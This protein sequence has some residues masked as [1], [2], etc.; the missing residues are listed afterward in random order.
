MK[1]IAIPSFPID[2]SIGKLLLLFY[3]LLW[4]ERYGRYL[5]IHWWNWCWWCV[6]VILLLIIGVDTVLLK[7][8]EWPCWPGDI[9]VGL[10]PMVLKWHY[11]TD[12]WLCD[13]VLIWPIEV[14][15]K[16]V[17]SKPVLKKW[18]PSGRNIERKLLSL[19][20]NYGI[21]MS[22]FLCDVKYYW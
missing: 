18:R 7:R 19:F 8:A 5:C 1:F 2:W 21:D 10:M 16:Y 17:Y 20:W 13:V 12:W 11:S 14:I 3:S 6:P 4:W 15:P 22:T 9:V